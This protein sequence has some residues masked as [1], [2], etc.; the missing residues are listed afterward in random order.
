MQKPTEA[1]N[2]SREEHNHKYHDH[3]HDYKRE[4]KRTSMDHHDRDHDNHHRVS[5][6]HRDSYLPRH[7]LKRK[8][9]HYEVDYDMDQESRPCGRSKSSSSRQQPFKASAGLSDKH[10]MRAYSRINFQDEE[11]SKKRRQVCV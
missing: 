8:P 10:K 1:R 2:S 3:D 7:A 4:N 6:S 9:G 11:P 5:H